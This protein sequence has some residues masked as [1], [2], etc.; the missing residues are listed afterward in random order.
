MTL[1]I[2]EEIV[3]KAVDG[4]KYS[5][6]NAHM[7]HNLEDAVSYWN[8]CGRYHGAKSQALRKWMLDFNNY[9]LEYELGNCSRGAKS[10]ERYKKSRKPSLRSPEKG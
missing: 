8:R 4:N 9:R 3:F 1:Q 2:L 5:L 7:G 10:K 6:R